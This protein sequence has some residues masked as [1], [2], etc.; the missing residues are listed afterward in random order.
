MYMALYY[1]SALRRFLNITQK[2]LFSAI[3][4]SHATWLYS[5]LTPMS[6]VNIVH[7]NHEYNYNS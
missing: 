2:C 5:L 3:K 7:K 1:S 4:N 6:L